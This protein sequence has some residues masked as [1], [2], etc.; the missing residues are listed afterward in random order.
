MPEVLLLVSSLGDQ[1]GP[2]S[3]FRTNNKCN[4]KL[5]RSNS[6]YRQQQFN[7]DSRARVVK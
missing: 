1:D 2:V 3:Q 4:N 7:K 6:K 5:N